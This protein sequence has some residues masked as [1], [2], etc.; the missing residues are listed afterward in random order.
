MKG[1]RSTQTQISCL[2]PLPPLVISSHVTRH[3]PLVTGLSP[4]S[5]FCQK[6]VDDPALVASISSVGKKNPQLPIPMKKFLLTTLAA[7]AFAVGTNAYAIIASDNA[8]N[9]GGVWNNGANG[10]TG[11]NAWAITSSNGTG[12]FGGNFLSSAAAS[13]SPSFAGIGGMSDVSFALYANPLG[14]GAYVDADR[15]FSSAMSVGD[16]FSFQWGINFDSGSD[17]NIP[18]T[19]YKGFNLYSGG[20]GGTQLIYVANAGSSDITVNGNNTGFDYGTNAMTWT[21][22][23]TSASNLSISA[24][25]RNATNSS[26][27]TNLTVAGAPDA[28][29]FYASGMQAGN[30]AQPYFNNLSV[31]PEPSTYALLAL[32]AAGLA[33]YAARRRA[34]K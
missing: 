22:T 26:Y 28:I 5:H 20:T 32:S 24:T 31:V 6:S 27:N 1:R 7:A 8:G 34:R 16:V 29:R 3:T 12:G 2:R 14:S 17:T 11:F 25:P 9:Y 23:L 19:G 13:N 21:F 30:A 10:G 15:G 33:G 4:P 18:V